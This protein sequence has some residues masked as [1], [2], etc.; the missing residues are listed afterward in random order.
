MKE[1]EVICYCGSPAKLQSNSV[2]YGKEYGNGR[3]YICTR[4][5]DCR[6][7]VGTHPNGK[8]LGHIPDEQ[9]KVMRRKLHAIVDPLWQNSGVR[10][11][12]KARGSVYGYLQRIT[13]LSPKECHI[14]MMTAEQC[15]ETMKAIRENPYRERN[16]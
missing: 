6:G 10:S 7:S 3:A 4:F 16:V 11:R 12:K 15:L 2:L 1:S 5:P 13:G 14:G 9:T 8:P